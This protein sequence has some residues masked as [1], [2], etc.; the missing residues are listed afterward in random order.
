MRTRDILRRG[1]TWLRR[2]SADTRGQSLVEF[3]FV[4]PMLVV[5]IVGMVDF[6]RLWMQYQIITD[7]AREAAR[8]AVIAS[9]DDADAKKSAVVA[10]LTTAM[11]TMGIANSVA[12]FWDC[13]SAAGAATDVEVYECGWGGLRGTPATV[14]IRAP[15]RFAF[16]GPFIGWVN[17][18]DQTITL[19]T[20]ITMRNE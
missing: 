14:T 6:A 7:A 13:Q 17:E 18:G 16:L 19:T 5:M 1:R 2:A 11:Q 15:Y 12:P 4:L 10:D 20:S 8:Q 3:A 9:E